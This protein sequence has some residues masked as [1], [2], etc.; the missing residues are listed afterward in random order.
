MATRRLF[1]AIPLSEQ[2]I[3][4]IDTMIPQRGPREIRWTERENL[5]FTL[6]FLGDREDEELEDICN[7]IEQIAAKQWPFVMR[8][9]GYKTM[10]KNR[11]PSMIW[12]TFRESESYNEFSAEYGKALDG[13]LR[14]EPI[15]HITLG[16]IRSN[17]GSF[18]RA[19]KMNHITPFELDVEK[20]QLWESEF[21]DNGIS[22]KIL[23]TFDMRPEEDDVE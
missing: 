13:D 5:H 23:R 3:D 17:A 22:Y 7:T 18:V 4:T 14:N 6:S 19:P 1:V 8:F 20:I 10:Y 12:A 11:K 15:P 21:G 16:R 2:I 9:Q